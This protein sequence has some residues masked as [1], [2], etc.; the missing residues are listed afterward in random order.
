MKNFQPSGNAYQIANNGIV[1]GSTYTFSAYFFFQSAYPAGTLTNME[2]IWLN[3]GGTP[4]G[5]AAINSFD[6]STYTLNTWLP[7]TL[8][9]MAPAN[10]AQ[11]EVSFGFTE[12]QNTGLNGQSAFVDD[13]D[14]EGAGVAPTT[15]TWAINGSGDWNATG[16]WTTGSVPNS[17]GIEADFGTISQANNT[18]YS[19]TPITVGTINFNNVNEY[20]IAGAG[21][22]TLQ[23]STG[24]AQVIVQ[25]GT[26]EINLP[27]TIA[28][29][30][31]FNVSSGATLV[32]ADP[33]TVNSG[34]SITQ[35]GSGTVTYES[36]ITMLSNSNLAI[37]NSTYAHSLSETTGSL[38]TLT[39]H[40]GSTPT[41]LQL[42]LLS[43]GGSTNSWQGKLDIA[44]ND[45]I[46]HNGNLANITNQI[47]RVTTAG[48]DGRGRDHIVQCCRYEQHRH[49]SGT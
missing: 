5:T 21:S 47:S 6:G 37:G 23:A 13:A 34:D 42:D 48:M 3:S 44:N 8:T 17:V 9:A 29:N 32:M 18:V 43:L 33:I 10:T 45:M 11:I 24:N 46:V 41:I 16:N 19:N 35:T 1:A 27:T 38:T 2:M 7:F 15:D 26:Q 49:R 25:E 14:L 20:V 4:V 12:G 31:V 36:T 30:T 28:S 22:L 39:A 40:L